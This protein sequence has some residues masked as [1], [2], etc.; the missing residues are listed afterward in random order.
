MTTTATFPPND[1][2][3]I[4]GTCA[5]HPVATCSRCRDA[6]CFSELGALRSDEDREASGMIID[7]GE[8]GNHCPTWINVSTKPITAAIN[9]NTKRP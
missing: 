9:T 7:Q 1:R 4:S 3:T 6:W 5:D 2:T 8:P